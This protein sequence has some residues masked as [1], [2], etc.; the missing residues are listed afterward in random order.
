[1]FWEVRE[2][3]LLEHMHTLASTALTYSIS[4]FE[5]E[6]NNDIFILNH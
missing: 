5:A 6:K 3:I 4:S 1:M 2:E